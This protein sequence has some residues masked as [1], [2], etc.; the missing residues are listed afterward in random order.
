MEESTHEFAA[1]EGQETQ[2]S[3]AEEQQGWLGYHRLAGG[4]KQVR[5]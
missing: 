4:G 2:E 1:R 3:R 5:Y